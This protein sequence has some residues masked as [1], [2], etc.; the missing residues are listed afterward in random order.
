LQTAGAS[1]DHSNLKQPSVVTLAG[2]G[3]PGF[4]NGPSHQATFVGP[5]GVAVAADGSIYVA[6]EYGQAIR[7]IKKGV[8][9]TVAGIS[10]SGATGQDRIGGYV[11]GPVSVAKFNH[12]SG[13]AVA[14]D[15]TIF[16]ADSGNRA[17]RKIA[18]GEVSTFTHFGFAD[19]HDIAIDGDGNLYVA[20]FTAGVRKVAPNGAVTPLSYTKDPFI[21]GIS[22]RGSGKKMI[23]AYTDRY[24]IN[25]VSAFGVKTLPFTAEAEPQGDGKPVGFA[26][27]LAVYDRYTVVTSDIRTNTIRLVRFGLDSPF[28]TMAMVRAVAGGNVQTENLGGDRDGPIGSATVDLPGGLAIASGNSVVFSDTGSRKIREVIGLDPR[29]PLFP[30]LQGLVG[31]TN[32]YRIAVIGASFV[33]ANVLWSE[34]IAGQIESGLAAQGPKYGLRRCPYV[35]TI[36]ASGMSIADGTNFIKQYLSDGEV[37]LVVYQVDSYNL[38]HDIEPHPEL[39]AGDRWKSVLAAD[40]ADASR[41]LQHSGAKLL[42]VPVPQGR[43]VSPLERPIDIDE[44]FAE[45]Q[46]RDSAYENAIASSGVPTLKLLHPLEALEERPN[47]IPYFNTADPHP[48]PEGQMWIG[49]AILQYLESWRPWSQK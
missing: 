49:R 4:R 47:R 20:D 10:S 25:I 36:R 11:D 33:F 31:P 44:S 46:A 38:V 3:A 26:C 27:R 14:R 13:V 34:S 19:P 12:P 5:V 42:M 30:G 39:A 15:G 40:I 24:A 1:C 43:A 45:S 41:A 48:S 32:R 22:V 6:D 16:V 29:G 21:C 35:V 37:D 23:L 2:S 8:V 28:T 17:I 18:R 7:R 9:Q